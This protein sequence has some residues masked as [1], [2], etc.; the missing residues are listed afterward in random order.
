MLTKIPALNN[1]VLKS[2]KI[3]PAKKSFSD[4]FNHKKNILDTMTNNHE[5]ATKFI[6]NSISNKNY[7]PEILLNKQLTIGMILLREQMYA[8]TVEISAN[9]FKN[10]TQ[11]QV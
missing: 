10:F 11:M 5:L 8:R 2:P 4:M 7:N 9:T 1:F 3:S 6:N